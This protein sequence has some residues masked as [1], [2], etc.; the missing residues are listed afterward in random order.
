MTVTADD[1]E[2]RLH[3]AGRA[4][5]AAHGVCWDEICNGG[6]RPATKPELRY[7]FRYGVL[8]QVAEW[9]A[10]ARRDPPPDVAALPLGMQSFLA[11][12]DPLATAAA[13][14]SEAAAHHLREAEA[15]AADWTAGRAPDP[16]EPEAQAPAAAPA[17]VTLAVPASPD[18]A[19][20]QKAPASASAADMLAAVTARAA[21]RRT[22][23][24]VAAA[25]T[26]FLA[27]RPRTR[28]EF[29][30]FVRAHGRLPASVMDEIGA[31]DE[32]GHVHLGGDHN[33]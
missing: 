29:S 1:V 7:P 3:A 26:A 33:G 16:R 23:S 10:G 28:S 14:D 9:L 22:L 13:P 27:E 30:V 6:P 32:D 15:L 25:A 24:P 11:M 20:P 2:E 18:A 4:W 21:G 31:C 5:A 19:T 17:H 12:A 8:H